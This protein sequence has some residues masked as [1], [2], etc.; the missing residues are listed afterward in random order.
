MSFQAQLSF[1]FLLVAF[2]T[3][4]GL[5]YN[6]KMVVSISCKKC[7]S[8]SVGYD[9]LDSILT[10]SY[11]MSNIVVIFGEFFVFFIITD[12]FA[13]QFGFCFRQFNHVIKDYDK[14][15]CLTCSYIKTILSGLLCIQ[16][17]ISL[18]NDGSLFL[19]IM[20]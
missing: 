18:F 20:I 10:V 19:V 11:A 2:T 7:N 17:N 15:L 9:R 1:E 8:S 4:F 5:V 3:I 14:T 16:S 6:I 13:F 12:S